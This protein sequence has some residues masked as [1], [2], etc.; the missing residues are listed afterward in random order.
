VIYESLLNNLQEKEEQICKQRIWMS[1]DKFETKV[2]DL[3]N[4]KEQLLESAVPS[5]DL[6]EDAILHYM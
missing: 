6:P 3:K 1:E 2:H 4:E 5:C